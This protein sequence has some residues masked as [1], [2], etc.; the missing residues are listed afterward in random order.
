MRTYSQVGA[1]LVGT[2]KKRLLLSMLL[3]SAC[4]KSQKSFHAYFFGR[5]LLVL[6]LQELALIQQMLPEELLLLIF[7]QLPS[8]GLGPVQCTCKQWKAVS[9]YPSLWKAACMEAFQAS[10][11]E[12][13]CKIVRS[14]HR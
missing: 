6:P 12:E 3:L 2:A 14:G 9:S 5:A 8:Y 10:G 1:C 4:D 7:S 13:N 11:Y